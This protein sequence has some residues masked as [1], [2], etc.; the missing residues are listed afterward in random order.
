MNAFRSQRGVGF[1]A[2]LTIIALLT[3]V[4]LATARLHN[5]ANTGERVERVREELLQQA[6]LVQG[7]LIACM[8]SWPGGDNGTGYRV[9]YPAA[10]TATAVSAL[11]CPGAPAALQPL[12]HGA[13]GVLPP[14]QMP[15]FGAW[16]YVNDATSMRVSITAANSYPY[17]TA[18]LA[19]AALRLGSTQASISGSTLT[20][21]LSN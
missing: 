10:L 7:K 8:A 18:A 2:V 15:D 5:A 11:A 14:R 19:S 16:S 6:S 20:I 9:A 3:A 21:V 13:D 4:S 17:T 1:A 12:W